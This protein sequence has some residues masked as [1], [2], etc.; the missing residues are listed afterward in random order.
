MTYKTVDWVNWFED[1]SP[2][3]LQTQSWRIANGT[4]AS[5]TET[6]SL[7]RKLIWICRLQNDVNLFV[8]HT[9]VMLRQ[10]LSILASMFAILGLISHIML[11]FMIHGEFVLLQ[12]HQFAPN[13]SNTPRHHSCRGMCKIFQLPFYTLRMGTKRNPRRVWIASE[14]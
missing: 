9:Q 14:K 6:K 4:N 11:V 2:A 1:L 13:F 12:D 8:H 10:P 5:K 3:R 7:S